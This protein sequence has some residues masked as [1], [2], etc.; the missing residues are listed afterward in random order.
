[1]DVPRKA[2]ERSSGHSLMVMRWQVFRTIDPPDWARRSR[3]MGKGVKR[4][5]TFIYWASNWFLMHTYDGFF[6][7]RFHFR[8]HWPHDDLMTN[9]SS[10][11]FHILYPSSIFFFSRLGHMVF[12]FWRVFHSFLSGLTNVH[13]MQMRKVMKPCKRWINSD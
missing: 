11:T 3:R 6:F 12:H 13:I 9:L 8:H 7:H 2:W 10:A 4:R 1:M 5:F